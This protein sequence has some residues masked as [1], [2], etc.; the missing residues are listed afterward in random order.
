VERAPIEFHE[1]GLRHGV[2]IGEAVEIEI[3]DIVPFGVETGR[4]AKMVGIFSP[5]GPELTISR[6]TSSKVDAF[7]V[8]YEANSAFSSAFSWAA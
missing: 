4:P 6:A 2:K 8:Q 3:E 5:V 1:D 7:G